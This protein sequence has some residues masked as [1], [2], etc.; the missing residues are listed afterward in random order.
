M[1]ADDIRDIKGIFTFANW[2]NLFGIL[3]LI[4]AA[5]AIGWWLYKK[6]KQKKEVGP[7]SFALQKNPYE[8]V[9]ERLAALREQTLSPS[10]IKS[11][12]F[13]LSEVLRFYLETR[14]GFPATERTTDE[15]RAILHSSATLSDSQRRQI[16]E[17]MKQTDQVKF[18]DLIL[19]EEASK[20]LLEDASLFIRDTKP[21]EAPLQ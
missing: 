16:E 7:I 21:S 20:R 2:L 11:F 14:Y 15:I 18:T 6:M 3:F 17:L 1:N 4:L 12:H 8:L 5:A 19:S 13:E 9:M 10:T